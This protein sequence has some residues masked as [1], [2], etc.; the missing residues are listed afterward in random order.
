MDRSPDFCSALSVLIW[1]YQFSLGV[2][3][4]LERLTAAEQ[5]DR[6]DIW[7]FSLVFPTLRYVE[8]LSRAV[9]YN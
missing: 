7:L 1:Y 8:P 2:K 4:F 6:Y 5:A 9:H 3:R